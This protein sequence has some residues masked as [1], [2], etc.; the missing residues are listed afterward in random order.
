MKLATRINSVLPTVNGDI[1]QAI[2]LVS[3]VDGITS[4][5]L[6]FP[7]HFEQYTVSEVSYKLKDTGLEVNGLALRFRKHFING[8]LGNSNIE[9]AE[10]ALKLCYEAVDACRELNGKVITLWLGYEGFDYPFQIDYPKVWNQVKKF[11][12]KIADYAPDLKIS[13]EYKPYQERSYAFIDSIGSTML[14]VS[15]IN[16][17]NVGVT[18]DYCHMLMKRENPAY[19]LSIATERNKLFGVHIN[20][21]YGQHDDGLMVG[22]VSFMQTLEF[23]YY[24]KKG[25]YESA[26][27]FDTF[28]VREEPLAEIQQ[29]VEMIQEINKMI[30]TVGMSHIENVI[31]KNSA[32]EARQL[33]MKFLQNVNSTVTTK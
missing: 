5:D 18:V 29:N 15:E 1:L 10:D 8:E 26:I 20:D 31:S 27:Y 23:M 13:I 22:T 9:I 21:G 11:I 30:D 2:D 32:I 16:R 25:N 4:V 28:P 17:E 12:R 24:L 33:F 6:N 19:G 14:M 7:E 3:K